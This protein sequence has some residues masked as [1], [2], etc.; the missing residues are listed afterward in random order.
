MLVAVP[1]LAMLVAAWSVEPCK[2]GIGTASRLG[3]PACSML[4]NTGWPCPSCGMTTAVSA[5]VRGQV[6]ASLRAQPFGLPLAVAA[7][8]L[9]AV[10]LAQAVTGRD[11]LGR[12]RVR[13]WWLICGLVGMF[14]GWGILL[15]V[16]PAGGTWPM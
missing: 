3:M 7:A 15:C 10:G 8:V 2:S 4:V 11:A 6:A 5:A 16:G 14:V 13:W 1:S 12:L 9:A